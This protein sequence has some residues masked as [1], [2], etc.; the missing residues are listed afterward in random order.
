MTADKWPTVKCGNGDKI[1]LTFNDSKYNRFYTIFIAFVYGPLF[2]NNDQV[3]TVNGR[4]V[5]QRFQLD[6]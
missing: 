3:Q 2:I 4:L 5:I 6:F 1:K